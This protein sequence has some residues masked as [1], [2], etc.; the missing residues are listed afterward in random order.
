[1]CIFRIST[2][3]LHPI[4]KILGTKN[5]IAMYKIPY[6][7]VPLNSKSGKQ[8]ETYELKRYGATFRNGG[9]HNNRAAIQPQL[10]PTIT[11]IRRKL[12]L[13]KF[14]TSLNSIIVPSLC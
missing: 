7:S 5:V 6:Q 9:M 3:I 12:K 14:S 13:I 8:P 10:K 4:I 1:M 11:Y 2:L